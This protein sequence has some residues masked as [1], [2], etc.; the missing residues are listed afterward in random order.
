MVIG[1]APVIRRANR[2]G[3][4]ISHVP[5]R[6][7]SSMTETPWAASDFAVFSSDQFAVP[8]G[9]SRTSSVYS[10]FCTSNARCALRGNGK[11][12]TASLCMP[13][14][15]SWSAAEQL[16]SGLNAGPSESGSPQEMN[17]RAV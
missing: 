2:E 3:R 4:L 15:C 17:G 9:K 16:A 8:S 5:R 11:N 13:H 12:Q 14:C 7:R 6:Q 10:W 1:V